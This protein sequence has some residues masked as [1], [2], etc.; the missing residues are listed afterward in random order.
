MGQY[1]AKVNFGY[2]KLLTLGDIVNLSDAEY[3]RFQ[4]LVEEVND[5]SGI[6]DINKPNKNYTKGRRK[7]L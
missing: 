7:K 6:A 4:H 5:S 3:E 1:R 2:Y